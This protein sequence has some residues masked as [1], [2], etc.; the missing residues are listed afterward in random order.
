MP[1]ERKLDPA[2]LFGTAADG[3]VTVDLVVRADAPLSGDRADLLDRL[4]E[5]RSVGTIAEFTVSRWPDD[6]VVSGADDRHEAVDRF[7]TF[8]EWADRRGLSLAPAFET[9]TVSP[10]AG[11]RRTV[12]TVPVAAMAVYGDGDL[13][14]VFPCTDGD[15]TWTAA[16]YL[17]AHE[18]RTADGR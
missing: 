10:L 8:R 6:L 14:G 2:D 3:A 15:R 7:E 4:T 18:A 16:D 5:L 9:R 11:S 1:T 13:T 12:L 17:D